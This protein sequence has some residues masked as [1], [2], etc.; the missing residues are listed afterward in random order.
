[1]RLV[2]LE[3]LFRRS[4]PTGAL[5]IRLQ[6]P[7]R[8]ALQGLLNVAVFRLDQIVLAL[9]LFLFHAAPPQEQLGIYVYL[10]RFPELANGLLVIV[11][12]VLFPLHHLQPVTA[13]RPAQPALRLFVP[14]G[15]AA[16]VG[17]ATV[18]A[19]AAYLKADGGF[20]LGLAALFLLQVP[21][22][23]LANL[24]TYSM[25][26]QGHLPGLLRN[27]GIACAAGS[28]VAV[29]AVCTSSIML[30]AAVVPIQLAAFIALSL[31]VRWGPAIPL[32]DFA[33]SR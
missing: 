6:A 2:F 5:P 24:A 11:G 7:L 4:A 9:M 14:L 3:A 28:A 18:V 22:I 26:S 32:Y 8:F 29:L 13:G 21:L 19:A 1:L 17:T 31:R 12:T 10:A 23:M 16:A 27:L 20:P 25:Q 15:L 30:M 33:Q